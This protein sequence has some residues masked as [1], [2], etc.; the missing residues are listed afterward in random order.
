MTSSLSLQ[1]HYE[2]LLTENP[3]WLTACERSLM[4]GNWSQGQIN[5]TI[6]DKLSG[7]AE[8][9]HGNLVCF[10]DMTCHQYKP[11]L[12]PDK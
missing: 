1:R 5:K 9:F 4:A 3:D 10:G 11:G 8:Y 12:F 7:I 2:E 6:I